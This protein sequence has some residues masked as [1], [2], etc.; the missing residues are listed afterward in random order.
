MKF[1]LP[2]TI[3]CDD[4]LHELIARRPET[5]RRV[6]EDTMKKEVREAQEL[7]MIN[8]IE[9]LKKA[10]SVVVAVDGWTSKAFLGYLATFLQ[11]LDEEMTLHKMTIQFSHY[12]GRHTGKNIASVLQEA[13]VSVHLSVKQVQAYVTDNAANMKC[14]AKILKVR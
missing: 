1:K 14:A 5:Y 10:L 4:D 11:F 3:F 6:T 9:D 13:L 12:D 2:F 8:M 7:A